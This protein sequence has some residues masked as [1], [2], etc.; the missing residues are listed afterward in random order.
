MAAKTIMQDCWKDKISWD[1][2]LPQKLHSKWITFSGQLY[3]LR[4][5][6]IPRKLLIEN[7]THIEVHGFCDASKIGYGTCLYIQS[8]NVDGQVCV[9]LACAKSRV[10]PVKITTIPLLELYGALVLTR[11]FKKAS[12]AFNFAIARTIFWSDST[13]VLHWVKKSPQALKVFEGNCVTE[14]Q[15]LGNSIEWR[16]VSGKENPADLLSRGQTPCEFLENRIWFKG[17]TWL[18]QP[19]NAWPKGVE[20]KD[21]ILPGLRKNICLIVTPVECEL[22]KRFSS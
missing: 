15:T 1:E 7:P 9:R 18:A 2:S 11:L 4:E 17:P 13:I 20:V 14:I 3:H 5:L 12:S 6:S 16:H 19:E 22:F 10:A 21:I 8:C